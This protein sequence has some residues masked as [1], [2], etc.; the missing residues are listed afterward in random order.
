[1]KKRCIA[2]LGGLLSLCLAGCAVYVLSFGP[3]LLQEKDTFAII[4]AAARLKVTGADLSR[5]GPG[6][7]RWLMR[8]GRQYAPLDAYFGTRGWIHAKQQSAVGDYKRDGHHIYVRFKAFTP[9]YVLC[10]ADRKP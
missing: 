1:M 7:Q 5:V 4:V 9:E 6:G 2:R 8:A 3:A 10:Q